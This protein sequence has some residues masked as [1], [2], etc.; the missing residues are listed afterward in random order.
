MAETQITRI[1][2][3]IV[4]RAIHAPGRQPIVPVVGGGTNAVYQPGVNA[5]AI[6]NPLQRHPGRT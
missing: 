5:T 1:V 6:I 4:G 2:K 3:T